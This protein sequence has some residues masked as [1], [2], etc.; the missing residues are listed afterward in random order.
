M[1]A[2]KTPKADLENKKRIFM[3]IGLVFALL[4]VLVAFEWKQYER[5]EYDLGTL[6]M[7]FFEEEDI[8]ITRQEQPPPPPPP[9]PSQELVIVDD[10][11]EIEEE[12]TIDV[13]A[14][15]FTEVQEFAPIT[16]GAAEEEIE[17]DVIF[18][19]VEDQPQF[20]GGESARVKFLSDNLRYPTMARE[21]G[22]QGTVFVTFVVERDGSV[23]DVRVLRGIGGG[24]D[25]EAVRVVQNMPRWQPGRQRGQPVRVQFNMPIRFMLN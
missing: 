17:E 19:V 13:E 10:D 14:T 21:A 12:F 22:I 16:M 20:P 6:D 25:E 2:K 23:T 5:P 8:P 3:Q 9:E 24:C 4:G 11:V 1:E 18:T 15:V 7:D